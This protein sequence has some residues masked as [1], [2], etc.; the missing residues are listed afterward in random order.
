MKHG[1]FISEKIVFIKKKF[2]GFFRL[3][4]SFNKNKIL[5]L[6]KIILNVVYTYFMLENAVCLNFAG[7]QTAI[8]TRW[9]ASI[10]L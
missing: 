3:N 7:L 5:M 1:S 2:L 9:N 6:V 10:Y 8:K 4:L